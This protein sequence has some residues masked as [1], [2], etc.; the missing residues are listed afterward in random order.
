MFPSWSTRVL[1][2]WPPPS[3]PHSSQTPPGASPLL[4][5]DIP[6]GP[7]QSLREGH[8]G[9]GGQ[10]TWVYILVLPLTCQETLGKAWTFCEPVS[11][12]VTCTPHLS[13]SCRGQLW[14]DG[15]RELVLQTPDAE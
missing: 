11:S 5:A 10:A 14:D 8:P 13:P 2:S 15:R 1:L 6:W 3:V 7:A 4:L 12:S 9:A